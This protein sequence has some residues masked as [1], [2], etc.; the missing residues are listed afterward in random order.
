MRTVRTCLAVASLFVV[1]GTSGCGSSPSSAPLTADQYGAKYKFA[2]SAISGWTQDTS[3]GTP[4]YWAG[5][6]LVTVVDGAAG[7]YENDG[8]RQGMYQDLQGPGY[9]YCTFWA[10]DF[11]TAANATTMFNDKKAEQGASVTVPG[12]DLSVAAGNISPFSDPVFAHFGASYFELQ[13][14]GFGDQTPTT[15]TGCTTACSAAA[16]FLALLKSKTN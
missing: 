4:H 11:G 6:D 8:F 7:F 9:N 3:S 13:L 1:F 15:G 5:T 16:Q 10:M 14:S 2:D 12:Y